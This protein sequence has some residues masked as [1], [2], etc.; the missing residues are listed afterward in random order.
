MLKERIL[1]SADHAGFEMKEKVKQY[2]SEQGY[3]VEDLGTHSSERTD[4]PDYGHSLGFQIDKNP[5]L[6][7]ITLCGSGNG[8]AM[9]ANKHQQVRG[10]L[11]WNREISR[12][13]RA[14]NDSN[15]C[16]IP[17]RFVS[18]EE[19]REIVDAFL[20]TPFDGGRHEIR[21]NKIP[22]NTI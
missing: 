12:L 13:A 22:I 7:G 3:E 5:A 11:C 1:I 16:S 21:V 2:L 19:A 8:I 4:Y 9:A 10:A 15:V 14:H 17:A 20:Q 18:F 6:K